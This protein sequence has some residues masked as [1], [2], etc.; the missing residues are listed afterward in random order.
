V[1]DL[2]WFMRPRRG[3]RALGNR[4]ASGING[5]AST[6]LG[7]ALAGGGPTFALAGD[8]SLI[9]DQNGLLMARSEPIDLV[10]VVANNDGGGIFEFLPQA[11]LP[12][13]FERLFITP[14]GLD[15]SLLARLHGG[16]YARV[17]RASEL[18]PAVR[19]AA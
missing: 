3:L 8:L 1:R 17:E 5:F 2:E 15:L 18:G 10:L 6:A 11:E 4:G 12:E 9:H 16:R 19:A 7:V 13:H 14:H